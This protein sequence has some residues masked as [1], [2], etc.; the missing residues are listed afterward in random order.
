MQISVL[1]VASVVL[2]IA[3]P[4]C[5]LGPSEERINCLQQCAQRKDGCMLT[6]Q[7][8]SAVQS[9]DVESQRCSA[10]CPD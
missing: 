7:N 10:T 3:V 1:A 8:A 6:A 4:G 2:S 5:A 9:C